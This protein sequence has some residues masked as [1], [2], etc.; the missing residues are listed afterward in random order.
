MFSLFRRK[1]PEPEE[2]NRKQELDDALGKM[3]DKSKELHALIEQAH[4]AREEELGRA[5][6]TLRND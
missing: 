1:S 2:S 4:R 6:G 3:R 5:M